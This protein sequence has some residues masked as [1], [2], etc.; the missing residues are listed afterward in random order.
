MSARLRPARSDDAEGC[1]AIYAPIVRDTPI[2]FE[3]DPPTPADMGQRIAARPEL[4]WLVCEIDGAVAGYACAAPHRA[5]A[6]YRWSV[7]VSVYNHADWRRRGVGSALYHALFGILAHQGFHRAY[8]GITL[9]NPASVAL[10]EGCG[11]APLGVYKR[12]GFK[13]GA[14]HDV[15][16]WD[17]DLAEPT[18]P[19]APPR[20][21][22][23]LAG[24]AAVV[25]ALADGAAR[26]HSLR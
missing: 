12:V 16:W 21:F 25:R 24:D 19:P 14:W 3:I 22:A 5:R 26:L 8:A 9:P 15:G 1:A 11:F 6:A 18:L 4:P 2:S 17:R 13:C 20:P 7:D 23:E 10:H